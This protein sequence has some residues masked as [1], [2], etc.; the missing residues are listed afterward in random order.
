MVVVSPTSIATSAEAGRPVAVARN[1]PPIVGSVVATSDD[2]VLAP[3][4]PDAVCAAFGAFLLHIVIDSLIQL[5]FMLTGIALIIISWHRP[6]LQRTQRQFV[7]V[8]LTATR[9]FVCSR[10]IEY[11]FAIEQERQC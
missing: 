6:S 2:A 4:H 3:L 8:K 9:L 10:S 7:L 1:R 11:C 5:K